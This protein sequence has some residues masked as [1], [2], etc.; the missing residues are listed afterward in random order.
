M[1]GAIRKQAGSWVV[2]ILLGIL[3]ASFAI[4]GIGDIFRA[5]F[6]SDN[7]AEIGE[8]AISA[9]AFQSEFSRELRAWQQ[10]LPDFDVQTALGV[11]LDARVL[12][13]MVART[14]LD[15]EAFDLGLRVSDD[16]VAREIRGMD[17]FRDGAGGFNRLNYEQILRQNG[18]TQAQFEAQVRQDIARERVIEGVIGGRRAPSELT[19]T[20]YTHLRE[21]RSVDLLVVPNH[22]VAEPALP[23]E[24]ALDAFYRTHIDAYTAPEYRA[25]TY[26][27]LAPETMM[28]EIDV[29]EESIEDYY[30]HHLDSYIERETR[31]VSNAV[32]ASEEDAKASRDLIAA[33]AS[34]LEVATKATAA[35]ESDLNLGSLTQADLERRLGK[36]IAAAAFAL[37]AGETAQPLKNQFGAWSLIQVTSIQPGTSKTLDDVR[38]EIRRELALEDAKD[39]LY[40][41]VNSI[42]DELAAGATLEEVAER[43]DLSL[44]SVAS[45]DRAGLSAAGLRVGI[46]AGA[47]FL[48]AAFNRQQGDALEVTPGDDD[49]YFVIRVDSIAPSAPRPLDEVREKVTAAWKE[50]ERAAAA[51]KRAADLAAR[52]KGGANVKDLAAA[53]GLKLDAAPDL[54]RDGSVAHEFVSRQVL[55]AIFAGRLGE[56]GAGPTPSGDGQ[57][58]FVLRE[59]VPGDPTADPMAMTSLASSLNEAIADDLLSQYQTHLKNKLGVVV[60]RDVARQTVS[61]AAPQ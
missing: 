5:G 13:R 21:K 12:D 54:L 47:A 52:L 57:V 48:D 56:V 38:G 29:S 31:T 14:V 4:W 24:T 6:R 19:R 18:L 27:S 51:E 11:G 34:F 41:L 49:A 15:R 1:L 20:L 22:S 2:K 35:S 58:A 23:D 61:A 42:E 16:L 17:R 60:R 39:A 40:S 59:I 53:E 8:T 37:S 26:V 46:P 43:L 50:Q 25:L 10:S 28:P 7:V 9:D 45:T 44:H 30:E 33:G 3:V 36:D 55:D 32:F